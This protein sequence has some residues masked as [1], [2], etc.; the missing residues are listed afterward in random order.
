MGL[1]SDSKH[2][3]DSPE[4]MAEKVLVRKVRQNGDKQAYEELFR[5]YHK[6][7]HGFAYTFVRQAETAEDIIQTVFLNIWADKQNWDPPGTVREYLFAAVRNQALNVL[8]HQKVVA[9]KEE[10]VIRSFEELSK[11]TLIH[12]HMDSGE[13]NKQVQ[14]G[15]ESLPPR[16]RQIYLLNRRSGLTYIEIAE[17]LGVSI[18]TVNTQM[19]RALKSLR[20]HLADFLPAF[21]AVGITKLFM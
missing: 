4:H 1:K 7:L 5:L 16:C 18:N 8:R 20:D 15:I 2:I 17:Y 9:D 12:D 10:E 3:F 6:R 11:A 21:I 13:F 19:G 14:Q